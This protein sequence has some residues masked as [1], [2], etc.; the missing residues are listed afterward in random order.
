MAIKISGNTVID[1]GRQLNVTGINTLGNVRIS[2]GIITA[3][4]GIVTYYGDGSNL[5]GVVSGVEL[6]SA[7]SSVGTGITS[8]NFASG[9]TLTNAS[10]GIS[11]VTIAAGGGSGE[12]NTGI[13]SSTHIKPLGYETTVFSFPSTSGKRY[14]IESIQATNVSSASTEVHLIAALNYNDNGRKVHFAYNVPLVP[15][16]SAELLKQ[17]H[18]ANPSDFITMWSNNYSYVGVSN[19]IEVYM[20]YTESDSTDYFG[21]GVSTAGIGTTAIT[22]VFTSTTYPS[23]IQ[24]IHLA[25]RTDDG[26]YAI[27]VLVTSGANTTYLAKDLVIP[28]YS[29]VELC[30]RPKRIETNGVVRISVGSTSSGGSPIDVSI[31]GKKITG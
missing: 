27:S 7:G 23:V 4:S 29:T 22:G 20:T 6:K 17:P 24:S 3:V 13:T 15:G 30:D 1:D 31:S 8:I 14:I 9:A 19:A 26:D 2:S 25:N 11:T 28:R 12:F 16:A 5:Q 21:V 10:G 18:I